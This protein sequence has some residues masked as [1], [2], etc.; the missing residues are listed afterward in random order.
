MRGRKPRPSALRRR[1]D[2]H[3]PVP[4]AALPRCPA[5]L[6]EVAR[7]EWRRLAG[8]LHVK[9]V[10]TVADRAAFA[11]YCQSWAR[12]VEAGLIGPDP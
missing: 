4:P 9:G 1:R 5:H 7:K 6:S 2:A 12:L 3:E 11:A 10:L 8:P